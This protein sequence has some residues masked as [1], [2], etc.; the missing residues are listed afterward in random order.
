M[1]GTL[2]PINW[3]YGTPMRG[4]SDVWLAAIFRLHVFARLAHDL[5]GDEIRPICMLGIGSVVP[6]CQPSGG[7]AAAFNIVVGIENFRFHVSLHP[8]SGKDS[9]QM[10]ATRCRGNDAQDVLFF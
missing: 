3:F 8:S 7:G 6:A 2:P 10:L 5:V 9:P 4:T 1:S